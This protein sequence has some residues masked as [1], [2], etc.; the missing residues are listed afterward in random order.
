MKKL[1]HGLKFY[2]KNYIKNGLG[3][4]W[5]WL[6][7][8]FSLFAALAAFGIGNAVQVGTIVSSVNTAIVSFSPDF[9]AQ[10]TVNLVLG[11]VIATLAGIVLFGGVKR[12]GAV[13]ERLVPIMALVYI[14]ASLSVIVAYGN[15]LPEVFSDIFVGA[16]SDRK[17]VV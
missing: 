1:E 6:G 15:T 12:L 11:L 14:I 16:Y 10:G 5:K 4:K 13:T 7:M 17:S 2:Q 9:G 8:L 3:E